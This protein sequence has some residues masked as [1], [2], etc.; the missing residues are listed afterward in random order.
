V[1]GGLRPVNVSQGVSD[2][3]LRSRR[4]HSGTSRHKVGVMVNDAGTPQK[5]QR[6]GL[7]KN[8]VIKGFLFE[9]CLSAKD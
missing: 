7:K 9:G 4:R 1:L 6:L 3:P 5:A 8:Y 2:C